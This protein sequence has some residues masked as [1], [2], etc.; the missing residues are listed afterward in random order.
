ME[1]DGQIDVLDL[2]LIWLLVESQ[3][4]SESK[5]AGYI[6]SLPLESTHPLSVP[7]EQ[8]ELLPGQTRVELKKDY[9]ELLTRFER[10]KSVQ[11][12]T[13]VSII[14]NLTLTKFKWAYWVIR[15]RWVACYDYDTRNI[16]K[17]WLLIGTDKDNGALCPWFDMFNHSESGANVSYNYV[18]EKG[19]IMKCITDIRQGDEIFISYGGRPD[20]DMF[21]DYGFAPG[22]NEESYI[23]FTLEELIPHLWRQFGLKNKQVS[24]LDQYEQRRFRLYQAGIGYELE[25]FLMKLTKNMNPF[26]CEQKCL[27]F[28]V[29]ICRQK[30]K[31]LDRLEKIE[32]NDN[33]YDFWCSAKRLRK[34]HRSI[35][36]TSIDV[37]IKRIELQTRL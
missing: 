37:Y 10:I 35:L 7:K 34:I 4:G 1:W 16:D 24:N 2:I 30:I 21:L 6:S 29:S 20:D 31:K 11:K 26:D 3:K 13:C 12:S 28:L 32:V 25:T 33:F 8:W 17:R 15:S 18:A 27:E 5:F 14:N 23:L 19:M 9:E 22:D 36:Q